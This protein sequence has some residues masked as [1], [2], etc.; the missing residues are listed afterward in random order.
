MRVP[1]ATA[2]GLLA[3]IAAPRAAWAFL[4]V[5]CHYSENDF[6]GAEAVVIGRVTK[7]ERVTTKLPAGKET[8]LQF[9]YIATIT[10]G[11]VLKGDV[12]NG[13]ELY[14]YIGDYVQP[15]ED[16][17][18]PQQFST[19]NTH[20]ALPLEI[21]NVYL[22]CLRHGEGH[23]P[24]ELP[25]SWRRKL[26]A[27]NH[28]HYCIHQIAWTFSG[29]DHSRTVVVLESQGRGEPRPPVPLADFLKQKMGSPELEKAGK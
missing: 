15:A 9:C 13:S 17:T 6:S 20:G 16:N 12:K 18:L 7:V 27:P 19:C 11:R 2:L 25:R 21:N 14:I 29:D 4:P 5:D 1:G 3:L 28:C 10:V 23:A 8:R 22:L 26:W 24:R